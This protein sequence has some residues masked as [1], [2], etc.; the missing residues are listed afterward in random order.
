MSLATASAIDYVSFSSKAS[1]IESL[2]E[3]LILPALIDHLDV[4]ITEAIELFDI[5]G[6]KSNDEK[7]KEIQRRRINEFIANLNMIQ[8]MLN[9]LYTNSTR[10]LQPFNAHIVRIFE[11]VISKLVISY[12]EQ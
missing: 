11:K 9:W 4:K 7:L 12:F 1:P 8:S 5:I 6:D 10:S 2:N 3:K